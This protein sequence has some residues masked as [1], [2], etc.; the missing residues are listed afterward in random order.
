MYIK[1]R[2]YELQLTNEVLQPCPNLADENQI[3]MIS[4]KKKKFKKKKE[5]ATFHGELA[6]KVGYLLQL[7]VA[8]P[9]HTA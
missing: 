2:T 1:K 8:S 9:A 5:K 6:F 4:Q 7:S 3:N